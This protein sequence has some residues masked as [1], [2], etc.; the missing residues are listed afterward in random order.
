MTGWY[1]PTTRYNKASDQISVEEQVGKN[2]SLLE[3]YRAL[4][5]LRNSNSA[6][7]RGSFEK[8]ALDDSKTYAYFRADEKSAFLIVLNLADA[9]SSLSLDLGNTSLPDGTYSAVDALTK[10]SFDLKGLI[11]NLNAEAKTS[12][13]LQLIK[14]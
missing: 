4:A 3:H 11:L 2:D 9:P 14:K 6:L 13:V 10:K 12:Y 1:K 7:R 5:L 8:I